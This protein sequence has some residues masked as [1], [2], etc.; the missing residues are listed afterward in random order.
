MLNAMVEIYSIVWK[1]MKENQECT[2]G[3]SSTRQELVLELLKDIN[4]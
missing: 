1:D 3:D 2:N 4:C